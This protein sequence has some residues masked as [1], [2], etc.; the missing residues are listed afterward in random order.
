[1]TPPG[2]PSRASIPSRWCATGVPLCGRCDG[3]LWLGRFRSDW[4]C[5]CAASARPG[6][7]RRPAT[8]PGPWSASR[9]KQGGLRISLRMCLRRRTI[10]VRGDL[11]D[12]AAATASDPR[13]ATPPP[14]GGNTP[15]WRSRWVDCLAMRNREEKQAAR[16]R[17]VADKALERRPHSTAIGGAAK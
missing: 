16:C 5:E 2:S 4:R 11:R 12:A 15:I 10:S 9:H 7:R 3:A 1:M 17:S 13:V 8:L 6:R 14:S